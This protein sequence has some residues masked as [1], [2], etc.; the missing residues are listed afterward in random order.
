LQTFGGEIVNTYSN[1]KAAKIS[2]EKGKMSGK[3]SEN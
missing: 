2:Q 3:I 1:T